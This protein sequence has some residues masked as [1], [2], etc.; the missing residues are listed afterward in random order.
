ML[1]QRIITAVILA[2]VTLWALLGWN[3]L[4][5]ALFLLALTS[6]CAW[7]WGDLVTVTPRSLRVAYGVI[8]VMV[9][10]VCLLNVDS[11]LLMPL[12]LTGVLFWIAI[13]GDLLVRPTIAATIAADNVEE[14]RWVLLALA[15]FLLLLCVC[16]LYWLR[17]AHG[18]AIVIYVIVLVAAA[19]TG[20]YFCG[21]KFGK[22]KLAEQ[23]SGGKTLEGA[24]GG[25]IAAMVLAVFAC[26]YLATDQIGA[27]SLFI[28]SF[29]AALVSI[30]GDLFVSRAKRTRDVKDS[31]NL[32]PGHGGVLDRFDGLLAAVPFIAFAALWA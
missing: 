16:C 17:Q 24:A 18:P 13:I 1:K 21:K 6:A 12:V 20:A 31:G 14:P 26:S 28:M 25:M 23:I 29:F 10:A 15:S 32:L 2:T 5:F 27:W 3:D 30:A 4:F 22:R 9:T 19:D 11:T 7:E 8:V